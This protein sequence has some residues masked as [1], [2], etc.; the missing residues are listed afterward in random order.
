MGDWESA[1]YADA[2][3]YAE[4][5]AKKMGDIDFEAGDSM[6]LSFGGDGDNGEYLIELLTQ[7]LIAVKTESG[8]SGV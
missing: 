8:M 2:Q 7:A 4:K 6:C 1:E 5:L 3:T